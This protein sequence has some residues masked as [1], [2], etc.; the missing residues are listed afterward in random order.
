MMDVWTNGSF[1]KIKN[2]ISCDSIFA[3]CF[4]LKN[5]CVIIKNSIESILHKCDKITCFK[6]HKYFIINILI[7]NLMTL[8]L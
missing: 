5:K 1:V 4:K 2:E 8:R 3:Y 7:K 6:N